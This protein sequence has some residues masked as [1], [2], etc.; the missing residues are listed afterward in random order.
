MFAARDPSSGH[1][2]SIAECAGHVLITRLNQSEQ[3]TESEHV[4]RLFEEVEKVCPAEQCPQFCVFHGLAL[5]ICFQQS[6]LYDHCKRVT[7]QFNKG[8]ALLP[9]DHAL[10]PLAQ[11]GIAM[12][13]HHRFTHDKNITSLE[14]SIHN[15]RAA[16]DACPRGQSMRPECLALLSSSLRWGHAFFGNAE[17]L[18]EA[19]SHIQEG[20]SQEVPEPL[21][22]P[23][24]NAIED[25]ADVMVGRGRRE[26][27]RMIVY[28]LFKIYQDASV[29]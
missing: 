20:L 15:S 23:V 27:E 11:Q 14:E 8:L 28:F 12:V 7:V 2:G 17:F 9:P 13:L 19:D 10:H 22:V 6:N 4:L 1:I 26:R 18:Q 21:R 3:R 25:P 16:L 5:S 24:A 29:L